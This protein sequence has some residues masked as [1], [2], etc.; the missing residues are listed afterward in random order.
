MG[1]HWIDW[2]VLLGTLTFII[3][4]GIYVI[5][6]SEKSSSDF[7]VNKSPEAWWAIGL[8]VMATQASAITFMSTPGQA[9]QDG[10]GFVQFYFGLPI[11]MVIICLFF[12]PV[13]HKLNVYTA[14]EYLEN[15][16]DKKTRTLVATL[17]LLQRGIGTG[18][19]IYAPSIILSTIFRWDLSTLNILIGII[20]IIYTFIG[21]SKIVA[22]TQKQQM[23][24][25]LGGMLVALVITISMLPDHITLTDALKIAGGE[26]KLNLL[27][28]SLDPNNR[29][30][31]WSGITGGLFLSL[32]YFGTDQSQV[33]R[34]ISGDSLRESKLGLIFNG[35]M[36][37]PMQFFILLCG[38]MVWVFFQ[39]NN[40]PIFFNEHKLSEIK[41]NESAQKSIDAVNVRYQDLLVERNILSNATSV[42][43][44]KYKALNKREKKIRSEVKNII[45]TSSSK[46]DANDKDYVFIYFVLHYLPKGVIGLLL[47]VVFCAAMSAASSALS[48]LATS[49]TLDIYQS[50]FN[51]TYNNVNIARWFTIL[52]GILMVVFANLCSLSENLIQFVNIIGSLFYGT[53]L[54]VFLAGFFC[55]SLTQKHIFLSAIIVELSVI[56]IYLAYDL[57]YLWLNPIGALGVIFI[58]YIIKFIYR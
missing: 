31:V 1:L 53:I 34:Y 57:G 11:A 28:F 41:L 27:D 49:T 14:Y 26:G 12:I 22:I 42:D 47:A 36:K 15:R 17:F 44:D 25:M 50:H 2:A 21:G 30:T 18:I 6:K 39:F 56:A 16:F 13:F 43:F 48:A 55:K 33:Q 46:Q 32:A 58:G 19:T 37:V 54:G 40:A 51:T 45:E 23:F 7:L 29:Y 38:L 24:V 8:S 52:W 3:G 9:Y 35:L 10:M 5:N 4:Y 20:V